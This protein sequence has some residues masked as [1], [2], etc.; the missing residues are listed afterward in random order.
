MFLCAEL[1]VWLIQVYTDTWITVTLVRSSSDA[2]VMWLNCLAFPDERH[3]HESRKTRQTSGTGSHRRKGTCWMNVR[4]CMHWKTLH[5]MDQ[6]P[7]CNFVLCFCPNRK[8]NPNIILKSYMKAEERG[9]TFVVAP[10]LA[11]VTS[12]FSSWVT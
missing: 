2:C 11:F 4:C 9:Q 5:M 1:R 10:L 3:D 6:L 8:K 7:L 12:Q